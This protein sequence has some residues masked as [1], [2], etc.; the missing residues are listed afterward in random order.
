MTYLFTAQHLNG[1]DSR[2]KTKT[3]ITGPPIHQHIYSEVHELHC[4][5]YEKDQGALFQDWVSILHIKCT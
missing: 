4:A 2:N 3:G 5:N 1:H